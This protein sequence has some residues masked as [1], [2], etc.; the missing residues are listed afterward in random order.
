MRFALLPVFL[1]AMGADAQMSS[2][3]I[4]L[5]V[6]GGMSVPTGGFS[7]AHELGVHADVSLLVNA[8]GQSLRLRPELSYTRFKLKDLQGLG[9][10]A[11]TVAAGES[12]VSTLLGGFANLELPLGHGNFQPF[13]LAG[14]GA[15]KLKTDATA[16][17]QTEAFSDIE[18]SLNFGAGIRFKLGSIGGFIEGR[19]NNVPS[20]AV[21]TTFKEARYIPVT[22]G[23]VF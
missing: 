23:L 1:V 6:S 22:F 5:V 12:D 3:P 4:Q 11:A 8:F 18:A 9:L 13:L 7:D 20:D 19:L 16:G 17:G 21:K 2:R 10:G 15:V 14:V